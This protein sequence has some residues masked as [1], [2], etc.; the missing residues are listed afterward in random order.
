MKA[1]ARHRSQISSLQEAENPKEPEK[2]YQNLQA[3]E[4]ISNY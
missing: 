2:L 1:S 3:R 4:S